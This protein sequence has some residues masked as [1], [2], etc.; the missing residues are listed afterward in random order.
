[1]RCL[2]GLERTAAR[3]PGPPDEAGGGPEQGARDRR[4]A[5]SYLLAA[6]RTDDAVER[7]ALRRSAAELILPRRS[8]LARTRGVALGRRG[9]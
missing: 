6:A 4:T 1:M 7:S 2:A 8:I 3:W 9:A 5:A